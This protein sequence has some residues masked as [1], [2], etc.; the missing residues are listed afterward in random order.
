MNSVVRG[1]IWLVVPFGV[2]LLI[3][4]ASVAGRG[5]RGAPEFE[6]RDAS[7]S[8][9]LQLVG[10]TISTTELNEIQSRASNV[11]HGVTA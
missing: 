9:A 4:T 10:S 1:T 8:N 2:S 11:E 6:G 7:L 5:E 3:A